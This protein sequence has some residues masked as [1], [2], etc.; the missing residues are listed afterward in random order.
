VKQEECTHDQIMFGSGDYYIFCQTCQAHWVMCAQDNGP[1]RADPAC[2]NKG[3][4][5]GL[6]GHSR[7]AQ[8]AALQ[9]KL[10]EAGKK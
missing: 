8:I 2:A 4:G 3:A 1:D 9:A 5:I 7:Y 6:S 10:E